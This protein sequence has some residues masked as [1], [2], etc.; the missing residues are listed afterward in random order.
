MRRNINSVNQKYGFSLNIGMYMFAKND[1]FRQLFTSGMNDESGKLG[2]LARPKIW[3][4]SFD[5]V[6]HN[7]DH[8]LR[9]PMMERKFATIR[10]WK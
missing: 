4:E 7:Q 9:L 10:F 3:S 8:P 6:P 1:V 5:V 2:F